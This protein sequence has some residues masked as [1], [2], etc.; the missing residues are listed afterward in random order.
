MEPSSA[1][2]PGHRGTPSRTSEAAVIPQQSRSTSHWRGFNLIELFSTSTRWAE[3]FPIRLGEGI[4][5]S[6][7]AAIAHLGFTWVRI[8]ASY[9][10]FGK[11]AFSKSIDASR[12]ALLDRAVELGRKYGI[13]V[14]LNL[15]RAPGYCVNSRSHFDVPEPGDLFSD[16]ERQALFLQYWSLIA[17]RYADVPPEALSFNLLNEPPQLDDSTFT[18]VFGPSAE[19]IWRRTAERLVLLEGWDAGLRP[20]PEEWTRH[21]Q[22]ITSVHLYKPFAITHYDC[23]WVEPVKAEPAW[24]LVQ[25]LDDGVRDGYVPL[26]GQTQA[27]WDRGAIE[28]IL[29]P[30]I[31]IVEAGGAVHVSEMGSYTG[32]P[33]DI[34]LAWLEASLGV[35]GDHGIGWGLWNFR[36]PFGVADTGRLDVQTVEF[37]GLSLDARLVELLRRH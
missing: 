13:H 24:P 2:R 3:E 26:E 22:V 34:E 36:G 9:L 16:P 20:P 8:P 19:A 17:E 7:F 32:V 15:H 28:R 21:P 23:P 25:P 35:L 5:E 29:A 27:V 18:S 10:W 33:H 31:E 30:W 11:G 1:A 12:F 4:Q 14:C 6:D 37:Q